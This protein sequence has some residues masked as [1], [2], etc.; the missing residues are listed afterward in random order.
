MTTTSDTPSPSPERSAKESVTR[1]AGVVGLATLLSRILGYA[2]DMIIADLFGAKA[3][4]DAFFVA[5]RI[6]SLLR[7]LT[8]EGAMSAAFVPVYTETRE[9]DG[10]PAAFLLI[11]NVITILTATLIAVTLLG[12]YFAL[13]LVTIIAP[14]FATNAETF[15][16]TVTLTKITL[17]FVI[18]VSMAAVVM[19][20]LNAHGRFFTP[21]AAPALLNVAIISCAYL[22]GDQL[23]HPAMALAIGVLIG[24]LLHLGV[25]MIPLFRLGYRYRPRFDIKDKAT[26]KIGLLM[27]PGIAGLAVAEVNVIVDTLLA[28][29]LPQ[30]SVSYLYYG[31]RIT[32]FPTGIFGAA[33]GV[34]ALPSMSAE[35]LKG[36]ACKLRELVSHTVRL[37]M[38]VAIP[39]TV[40]LIV[41]AGPIINVLF[42]RG[43]F[44]EAAR[45]GAVSALVWYAVGLFAFSGVKVLVS[46]FYALQDT[47]TPTKISGLA[48]LVNI[49]LNLLLMGPM[50]HGGLALATSLSSILNMGLL[51]FLL[52]R[53]IGSIDGR[54]IALSIFQMTL[55]ALVMGGAVFGYVTT[56]FVYNDPSLLRVIH[57][58]AA[59]GIGVTVY[60]YTAVLLGMKE[61]HAVRDRLHSKLRRKR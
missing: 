25:Q 7:R 26:R 19:G 3:A 4:A 43:A 21:A 60:Y 39:S 1:A 27:L 28:S 17:P 38:F 59:I 11:S 45:Y 48:M 18:F 9:T 12:E 6:P 10:K 42:E 55:A 33:I 58:M 2:R 41:L 54:R 53:R 36:G 51:A 20:T 5:F 14:G 16:L 15:A 52:R 49:G 37:S 61:A 34:A 35:T 50:A 47:A 29:L 31:N 56:Y 32:Q 22:L 46:A 8:A 13:E 24:G 44:G 57:L 30:G 23:P 40:G